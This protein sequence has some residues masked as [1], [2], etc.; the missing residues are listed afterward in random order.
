MTKTKAKRTSTSHSPSTVRLFFMGIVILGVIAGFTYYFLTNVLIG[1]KASTASEIA[2]KNN[3]YKT[4]CVAENGD[5][6]YERTPGK[7]TSG[8]NTG[9]YMISNGKLCQTCWGA[10]YAG[11]SLDVRNRPGG[12]WSPCR[13]NEGQKED[14]S[15]EPCKPQDY[16]PDGTGPCER[17]P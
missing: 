13:Y 16:N 10:A 15:C 17:K 7:Y 12:N 4:Y 9:F 6:C 1:S 11:R 8:P 2:R 3:I 5:Y 14:G